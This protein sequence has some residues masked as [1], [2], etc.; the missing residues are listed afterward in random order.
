MKVHLH[1]LEIDTI[2]LNRSIQQVQASLELSLWRHHRSEFY[3]KKNRRWKGRTIFL[4]KKQ[5]SFKRTWGLLYWTMT[6]CKKDWDRSNNKERLNHNQKDLFHNP[7]FLTTSRLSNETN[8]WKLILPKRM[9]KS[10]LKTSKFSSLRGTLNKWRDSMR[11]RV[12]TCRKTST[13]KNKRAQ[14][15]MPISNTTFSR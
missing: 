6:A 9:P 1:Y 13:S 14:S 10:R 15:T 2:W 12:E 7:T 3:K 11:K 8:F 5:M 4:S